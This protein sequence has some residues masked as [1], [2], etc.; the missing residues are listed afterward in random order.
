MPL[1]AWGSGVGCAAEGR[2]VVWRESRVVGGFLGDPLQWTVEGLSL[3][4]DALQ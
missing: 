3:G 1:G 4:N 2:V